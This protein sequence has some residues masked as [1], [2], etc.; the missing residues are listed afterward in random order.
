MPNAYDNVIVKAEDE[1]SRKTFKSAWAQKPCPPYLADFAAH[2]GAPTKR[3]NEQVKRNAER[4]PQDFMF[5]LT[6]QEKAEVVA[7]R[8][9]RPPAPN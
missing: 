1:I 4:F 9:L 6:A 3:L 8:L 7:N 5:T 2:Y